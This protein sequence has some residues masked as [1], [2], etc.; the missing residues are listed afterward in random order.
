ME[1]QDIYKEQENYGEQEV[2]GEQDFFGE[3][4][5]V[6][7]DTKKETDKKCPC[8]GGI[9]DFDP[10]V[11]NL[12]C[13]YCDHIEE[14]LAEG[15]EDVSAEEQDFLTEEQTGNCNWGVET[16]TVLCKACGGEMVYDALEIAGECPYCGSNQVMEAKGENT[17]AP[18]GVCVFKLDAKQAA[19]KFKAW[20]K[21]RWFCP[22]EA[23]E[24]ATPKEMKGLY[25]PYWTFDTDTVTQYSAEYGI[26]TSKK[27]AKGETVTVTNWYRC[28]GTYREFIDDQAVCG[29]T[30]HEQ[31]LLN[32]I[33][34]YRTSDNKVYKPEYIAGFASERYSIGLKD[35]W[36][37]AKSLITNRLRTNIT[38]KIETERHAD[39]VRSVRL[40]TSYSK[41]KYKYLLLPVWMAS[42]KYKEKL[43][44]FMVNGQTGK[45][46]GK[47]PL[48]PV[49]VAFSVIGIILVIALLWWIS[50]I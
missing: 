1:E 18:G 2:Y 31:G 19:E 35:A 28:S 9:M 38:R 5:P 49:K 40:K 39:S 26:N 42:F 3:Q 41:I 6:I 22:K 24:T 32:G 15:E 45:V 37:K 10:A 50:N 11:G 48:S 20:I 13:P 43:Y 34:P 17:L 33:Q 8:C 47:T 29:T 23:K 4:E 14:I 44:Q 12:H 16:K 27:N 36:E 7:A 21:K 25:L 30:R 46:S